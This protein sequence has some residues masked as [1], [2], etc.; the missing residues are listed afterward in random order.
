[1]IMNNKIY[2]N[3]MRFNKQADTMILIQI[4]EELKQIKDIL[5][6]RG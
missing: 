5:K 6:K 2:E 1:M 3:T 4:L